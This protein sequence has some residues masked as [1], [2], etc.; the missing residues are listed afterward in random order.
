MCFYRLVLYKNGRLR[1][2]FFLDLLLS[3]KVTKSILLKMFSKFE[4][5]SKYKLKS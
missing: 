2:I 1:L 4:V 5:V 3:Y